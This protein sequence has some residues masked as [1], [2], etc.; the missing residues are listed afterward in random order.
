[1]KS[2]KPLKNAHTSNDKLG[3]G[4]FMGT[5]IRNPLAKSIVNMAQKTPSASKMKKPRSLA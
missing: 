4:S 5:G 1:M 3:K 2:P